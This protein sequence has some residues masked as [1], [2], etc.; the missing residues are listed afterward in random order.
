MTDVDV[1]I[2][3]V[4]VDKNRDILFSEINVAEK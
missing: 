3:P 1:L 2:F 4:F